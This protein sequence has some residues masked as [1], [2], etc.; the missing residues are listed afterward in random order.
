MEKNLKL[1][2]RQKASIDKRPFTQAIFVGIALV[3][4]GW[5]VPA[6]ATLNVVNGDFSDMAGLTPHDSQGYYGTSAGWTSMVVRYYSVNVTSSFGN[7]T[8]PVAN[9]D[10]GVLKQNVGTTDSLPVVTLKFDMGTFGS[11]AYVTARIAVGATVYA[12]AS[13]GAGTSF[14]W[15]RPPSYFS[16]FI[17]DLIVVIVL[18][19]NWSLHSVIRPKLPMSSMN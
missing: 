19:N 15:V 16:R 7:P 17:Y 6:N 5:G 11:P 1:V 4:L 12:T 14:S 10:P 8:P 3:L 2:F 13:F 9:L 18:K